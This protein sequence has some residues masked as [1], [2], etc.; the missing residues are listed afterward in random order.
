MECLKVDRIPE[1]ELWQYELKLTGTAAS[2]SKSM[3][4]LSCFRVTETLSMQNFHRSWPL[5]EGCE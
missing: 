5:F 2:Q 4:T 1:G 3:V